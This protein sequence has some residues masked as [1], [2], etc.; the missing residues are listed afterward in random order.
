MRNNQIIKIRIYTKN[1]II[2]S[3]FDLNIN[4]NK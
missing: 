3:K 2:L 1:I 4:K